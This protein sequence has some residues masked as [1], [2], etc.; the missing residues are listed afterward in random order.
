MLKIVRL[1]LVVLFLAACKRGDKE[2]ATSPPPPISSTSPQT[3]P[4]GLATTPVEIVTEADEIGTVSLEKLN[5]HPYSNRIE[6]LNSYRLR[7]SW[8]VTAKAGSTLPSSF[9]GIELAHTNEPLA[10]EVAVF[11]GPPNNPSQIARAIMTANDVWYDEGRGFTQTS[12][13]GGLPFKDKIQILVDPTKSLVGD[14]VASGEEIISGVNAQRY[15]FDLSAAASSYF[16]TLQ[17]NIWIA[18]SGGYIVKGVFSAE[19]SQATYQWN[20]EIYDIDTAFT[21]QP[22]G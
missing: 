19:D 22:P 13:E 4:D 8:V 20:W 21:I 5:L 15:A 12:S 3:T 16:T 1:A 14:A 6:S 9:F 17:G 18:Q 7:V 10:T 2:E 11:S